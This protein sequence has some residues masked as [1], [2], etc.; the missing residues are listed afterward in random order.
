VP[1][2]TEVTHARAAACC[3]AFAGRTPGCRRITSRAST[4]TERLRI[5][6][7][8][9]IS[10]AWSITSSGSS[11]SSTPGISS[12]AFS[13]GKSSQEMPKCLTLPAFFSAASASPTSGVISSAGGLCSSSASTESNFS[14]RRLSSAA[15]VM[16]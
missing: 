15:A 2:I 3:K 9:R 16:Y 10:I 7:D 6:S 12:A 4:P 13:A 14:R 11:T 8:S 5:T 1:R